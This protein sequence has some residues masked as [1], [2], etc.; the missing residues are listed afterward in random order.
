M[1]Q[2]YR[3]RSDIFTLTWFHHILVFQNLYEGVK[4]I[5]AFLGLTLPEEKMQSIA[6]NATFQSMSS[7]SAETHGKF[8]PIIFRKGR[9]L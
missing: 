9:F 2:Q 6:E 7:K 4:K 3:K 5:A 1:I 8:G